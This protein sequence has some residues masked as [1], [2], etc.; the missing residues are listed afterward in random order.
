MIDLE[1]V[2]L[3]AIGNDAC[4]ISGL[5][6]GS[7]A[8]RDRTPE[9]TDRPHVGAVGQHRFDHTVGRETLSRRNRDRSEARNPTGLAGLN[10]SP[11]PHGF[12]DVHVDDR[13]GAGRRLIGQGY[14]RVG[15]PSL[16]AFV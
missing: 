9:M 1:A 3:V 8:R 15:G 14:Q 2:S 16:T 13:A 7:Y 12:V 4:L 10:P 11:F 6:R 5:Q